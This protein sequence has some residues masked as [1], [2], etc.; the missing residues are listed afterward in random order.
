MEAKIDLN[1]DARYCCQKT[2]INSTSGIFVS[3]PIISV[4]ASAVFSLVTS[5]TLIDLIP[6]ERRSCVDPALPTE[7]KIQNF[8]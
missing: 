3:M 5:A 8:I 2:Q 1:D 4:K 6:E 7:V